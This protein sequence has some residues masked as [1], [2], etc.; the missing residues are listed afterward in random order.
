MRLRVNAAAADYGRSERT[1][2][3]IRVRCEFV[4]SRA[5]VAPARNACLLILPHPCGRPG[6]LAP[7]ALAP[8]MTGQAELAV[9]NTQ[10]N[11]SMG[12]PAGSRRARVDDRRVVSGIVY[13]IRN[14]LQWKDGIVLL[15]ATSAFF[16]KLYGFYSQQKRHFDSARH[17]GAPAVRRTGAD[18]AYLPG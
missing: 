6:G 15:N 13:V 16:F 12:R 18:C 14:G 8:T 11:V 4:S 1:S 3:H 17:G 5:Q 2:V 9:H 10:D 7:L